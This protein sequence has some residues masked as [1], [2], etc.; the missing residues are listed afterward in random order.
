MF[1]AEKVTGRPLC[2][3][4]QPKGERFLEEGHTLCPTMP[5]HPANDYTWDGSAW[6]ETR[7]AKVR[8]V[9][10]DR[11]RAYPDSGDQLGALVKDSGYRQMRAG[12]LRSRV[13]GL[14]ASELADPE[15][16]RGVLLDILG[17]ADSVEELD[18]VI[19]KVNS[20][21]RDHPKLEDLP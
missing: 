8:A 12:S 21:K 13:V 6:I 18:S 14:S 19:G 1:V 16:V 4:G 5:P 15:T 3:S 10:S 2:M 20:A 9:D 17:L 11:R 7:E